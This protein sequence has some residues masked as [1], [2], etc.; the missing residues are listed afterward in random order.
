MAMERVKT[1]RKL[2]EEEAGDEL[3]AES[4]SNLSKLVLPPL[5]VSSHD[6]ANP[7]SGS[8]VISPM[9]TRYRVWQTFLVVLVAYCAWVY[10]FEIAFLGSAAQ[11]GLFIADNVISFFFAIDMALIF[12]VAYLDRRTQL[13]VSNRKKIAV[14]YLSTWFILDLASTVPF[15]L[16]VR[17]FTGR[18]SSRRTLRILGL[19]RLWRLRRVH[20]FFTRLEKDIRYHYFLVRCTRL[21]AVTLF[22]VHCFACGFFALAD[23]YPFVE[24]TW[25]GSALPDF[26]DGSIWSQYVASVYWAMTTMTTVGYGDLHAVNTREMIYTV[27]FMLFNLGFTSYLIGNM[28]NLVAAGS[29][30]TMRFRDSV[31]AAVNFG[32]RNRLPQRLREQIISYMCL[33]F[34]AESLNQQE[35]ME[36]LP[37]PI[38]RGVCQYLFLPTLKQV[39]LFKGVSMDTLLLLVSKMKA[40]YFPP[41]EEV[42][43]Q[44]QVSDDVF[45]VISGQIEIVKKDLDNEEVVGTL[46]PCAV[47][48]EICGL[49]NRPQTHTFKT[50]T[51]TQLLRL[52]HKCL[53]DALRTN[54][55]DS[56]TII[57][58]FVQRQIKLEDL[59]LKELLTTENGEGEDSVIPCD[60]LTVAATGNSYFL[61]ELIK[62]GMDPNVRDS[63][64]RTPLHIVAAK[65]FEDCAL[66]LIRNA[67]N[68]NLQD[69]DGNT[70]L[71]LAM[72][73]KHHT[74]FNLLY[75][76]M[77]VSNPTAGGDLLCLSVKRNDPSAIKELLTH[78]LSV[79]LM[80]RE[81]FT[82]LERALE[83]NNVEMVALLTS[84]G[85]T[86]MKRIPSGTMAITRTAFEE[87]TEEGRIFDTVEGGSQTGR[88]NVS[89]TWDSS[90]GVAPR[91]T[92]F[93]GHPLLGGSPWKSGILV[94][95]P[96]SFEELKEAMGN[97]YQL[98]N[99]SWV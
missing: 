70:A 52:K 80:D 6:I 98:L 24:K 46:G 82:A 10:P 61:E 21:L 62:A 22:L 79:D 23:H 1:P 66:V 43:L 34:R 96:S 93:K 83:E 14:R 42:I 84:N 4:L 77:A 88:R 30:R 59:Q 65:G 36:Q 49:C 16:L 29:R 89:Q 28:T 11:G 33:R 87:M 20:E 3:T 51:L 71:W 31:R 13:F 54:H 86:E 19:L 76:C 2:S 39:Y 47:F 56:V 67:C 81:G 60:L 74:V 26:M 53:L 63:K 99:S 18:T 50:K 69:A 38:Y 12:F 8:R 27:C 78:G 35:L 68:V 15:E 90:C 91:V 64:G 55:E 73:A 40:E 45:F 25:I 57:K 92:I 7:K 48:G 58:N 17:L 44:N 9:D 94:K 95:L 75:Q 37:E 72:K 85:A 32:G 5:G 97:H 41:K